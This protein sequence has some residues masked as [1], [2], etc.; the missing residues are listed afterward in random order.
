M[1]HTELTP[2]SRIFV[3]GHRGMVGSAIVRE[4][5]QKGLSNIVTRT[6]ADLDLTSQL[7]VRDF[8]QTEKLDC[9]ILA[10]AKVG[11]IHA[12]NVYPAEFIYQNLMMEANIIH[13]AYSVGIQKLLFLGSSCIYPKLAE[14]PMSE[15]ALLTGELEPT[16]EPYAIAKIAGIKLCESYNRQYGTDYRS[17]MPTNLY[18]PGDN[19]HPEN[20]HVIPALIRRFH[21]AKVTGAPTITIWGTGTP[22]REFLHVDDMAAASVYLRLLDKSRFD[23]QSSPMLSHINVGTGEDVTIRELAGLIADVVGYE[24]KL[25]FDDTKPDGTPRKLL[26]VSRI[27]NLGW[28]ASIPLK[29]GLE[30]TYSWYVSSD[31]LRL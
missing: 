8:F 21:E 25:E 19:F 29:Q 20:S 13:E 2:E 11:G 16:N 15:A 24:G 22:K 3:A 5:E 28:S 12:N 9:V 23:Q 7:S 27:N 31:G 10:A 17:I 30:E 1:N 4:L 18:G 6:H 14:Q 26:D